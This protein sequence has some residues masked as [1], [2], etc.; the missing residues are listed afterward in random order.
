MIFD[1]LFEGKIKQ[2]YLDLLERKASDLFNKQQREKIVERVLKSIKIVVMI[3][4]SLF[5]IRLFSNTIYNNLGF[6]K[7]IVLLTTIIL[8]RL[9]YK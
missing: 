6:E 8:I 5:L 9:F 3:G 7:T 1:K 2:K 4:T